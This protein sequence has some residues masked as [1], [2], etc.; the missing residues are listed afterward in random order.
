MAWR[1]PATAPGGHTARALRL[2]AHVESQD[3]GA[4]ELKGRLR[5]FNTC[6]HFTDGT[7][8]AQ[9]Q[10]QAEQGT[11]EPS[12]LALGICC[13]PVGLHPWEGGVVGAVPGTA[14]PGGSGSVG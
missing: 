13:P 4:S 12:T 14:A 7:A 9:S 6:T 11:V 3:R 5:I 10:L 2:R 8:G 1:A